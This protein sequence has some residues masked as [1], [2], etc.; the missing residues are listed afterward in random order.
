MSKAPVTIGKYRVERE[1]GRGASGTVYLA[2]DE[3]RQVQMA[4]KQIHDHLLADPAR[5]TRYRWPRA[6]DQ[7]RQG[8]HLDPGGPA[9]HHQRAA[10]GVG[11]RRAE[12]ARVLAQS[13][14]APDRRSYPG[15][16]APGQLDDCQSRRANCGYGWA[17][18]SNRDG[19]AA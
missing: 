16:V 7:F 14:P 13:G 2:R 9:D 1:L 12:T 8:L 17:G 19:D 10:G 6:A 18:V 5:S 3:F 11:Y 4:V 15:M